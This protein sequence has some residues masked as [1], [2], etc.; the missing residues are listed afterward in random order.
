[1]CSENTCRALEIGFRELPSAISV[2]VS[3][4]LLGRLNEN[5]VQYF[6]YMFCVIIRLYICK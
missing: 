4:C 3:S 2:L 5:V 6:V 1:M